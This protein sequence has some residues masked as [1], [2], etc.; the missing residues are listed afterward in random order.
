[1]QNLSE[2]SKGYIFEKKPLKL[3]PCS[4]FFQTV[5]WISWHFRMGKYQKLTKTLRNLKKIADFIK[6]NAK[7]RD[8]KML[9]T[10]PLLLE[11]IQCSIIKP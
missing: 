10:N 11:T 7:I 3:K 9:K 2:N 1:M 6:K 4:N 5:E 8:S